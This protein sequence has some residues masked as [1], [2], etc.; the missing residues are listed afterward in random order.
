MGTPLLTGEQ[1]QNRV[2]C[3]KPF[4]EKYEVWLKEAK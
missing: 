3:A 1:K 4:L 2:D